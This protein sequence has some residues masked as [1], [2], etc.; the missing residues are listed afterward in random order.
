MQGTATA[1]IDVDMDVDDE[2][3]SNG[4]IIN[5]QITVRNDGPCEA[6]GILV[7]DLLPPGLYYVS[8]TESQGKY[9]YQTGEW[10]IGSL[11]TKGP[12]A[13][14]ELSA[15]AKKPTSDDKITICFLIDSSMSISKANYDMMK[16]AIAQAI[17]TGVIPHNGNV[18]LA[19]MQFGTTGT[20]PYVTP[21]FET[22]AYQILTDTN[23]LSIANNIFNANPIGGYTPLAEAIYRA[24]TLLLLW[25]DSSAAFTPDPGPPES[26]V[27]LNLMTDGGSN[28][29]YTQDG[30][31]PQT[32]DVRYQTYQDVI[33]MRDDFIVR[34]KMSPDQ[35]EIDA[36]T[37]NGVSGHYT[38][39]IRNFVV[40]PQPG[41]GEVWP[42]TPPDDKGWA[43]LV[44][45]QQQI[46]DSIDF[47]MTEIVTSYTTTNTVEF[48]S[49]DLPDPN[50]RN[51]KVS[52][53]INIDP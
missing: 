49:S 16:F 30:V 28:M 52:I 1:D 7:K 11:D 9:T 24:G 35:D 22:L 33:R 12:P 10:E 53:T 34:H 6:D 44:A 31:P 51:D 27:I 37:V 29:W 3:P 14:L 26:I 47:Q 45:S 38:E 23:Y 39:W 32:D 19:V 25:Y 50:P 4:Q 42:P 48:I 41:V 36:M 13:T 21:T 46:V 15:Q 20:W 43:R 40:W 2:N 17:T 5:F 8:H 18:R